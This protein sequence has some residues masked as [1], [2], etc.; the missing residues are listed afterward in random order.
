MSISLCVFE[1]SMKAQR[2]GMRHELT[3]SPTL[4]PNDLLPLVTPSPPSVGGACGCHKAWPLT[5]SREPLKVE[6]AGVTLRVRRAGRASADFEDGGITGEGHR[7]APQS[8]MSP[9]D[10]QQERRPQPP[11]SEELGQH[12]ELGPVKP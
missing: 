12:P 6:G 4:L 10:I 8:R 11:S 3:V 2:E 5:W 1:Q 9:T 7:A